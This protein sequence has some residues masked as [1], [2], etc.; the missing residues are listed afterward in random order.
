ME[1]QADVTQHARRH[2]LRTS[3]RRANALGPS[4][5]LVVGWGAG[6][7]GG[8]V[9]ALPLIIWDWASSAHLALEFP[10][11]TTAWFFGLDHFSHQ[12]YHAWPILI[13]A[14]FLC[15]YWIVSGLAFTGIADRLYGVTTLGKSLVAGAAW[16]FV[17]F[18]L[19][20]YMLLPIARDGAPFRETAGAP[21]QFVAPNWVWIL[22]FTVFGLATGALYAALRSPAPAVDREA[23]NGQS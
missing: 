14:T 21:G 20:W 15:V 4:E 1:T 23:G 10:T 6:L 2:L 13:G 16:S 9:M 11:A 3:R 17:S 18:M 12:T 19:F 22:A 5:W 7:L 8:V